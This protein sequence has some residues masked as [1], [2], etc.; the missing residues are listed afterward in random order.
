[1]LRQRGGCETELFLHIGS[2]I[3]LSKNKIVKLNSSNPDVVPIL[4]KERTLVPLRMISEHFDAE[5]YFDGE[6][7]AAIIV[8]KDKTGV[9]PI[10]KQS[11][12]VN[13]RAYELDCESIIKNG[14]TMVP[15]RAIAESVLGVNVEYYEGVVYLSNKKGGFTPER[16]EEA[17]LKLGS[18]LKVS[19]Y[20]ELDNLV[21]WK[22]YYSGDY[23]EDKVIY[24]DEASAGWGSAPPPGGSAPA[25]SAPAE[26][27]APSAPEAPAEPAAPSTDFNNGDYS[28]TNIQVEG[29]DEGD[30][31][32]ADG[33]YIYMLPS[34]Q[35]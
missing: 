2:P 10:D 27:A 4:Y 23:E 24:E 13:N 26:P 21:T 18:A 16:V 14:R 35:K 20:E 5:V 33:E 25:P 15:L 32:K 11:F 7:K 34:Q 22:R 9:F 12:S 19:S 17:K 29:I 1:M 31:V 8:T 30:I 6:K 3:A 28:T